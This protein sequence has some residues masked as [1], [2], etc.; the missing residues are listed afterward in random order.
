MKL[1][2]L[3]ALLTMAAGLTISTE[4]M[5][6]VVVEWQN[7]DNA[8]NIQE[9]IDSGD[10][11]IIIPD[12]DKTWVV[13][14]PI[15]AD[16]PNQKIIFEPGV[17]VKAKKG[18]FKGNTDSLFSVQADKVTLSGYGATFKMQKDD[19]DNPNLYEPSQF[20]HNIKIRGARDFVVEGLILKDSGGDGIL[21][22]HGPS[23]KNSIPERKFSSGIVRD[24]I[25]NNNYRQGISVVSA[26]NL[27]VENSIFKNTSGVKPS[28]GVDIEPDHDWQKLVNIQFKN[29]EFINN[30]RHGIQIALGKY[31]G[32]NVSNV[33]IEFDGCKSINNQEYGIKIMGNNAGVD[34]GEGVKGK[35]AFKDCLVKNS[36]EHGIWMRNDQ[37]DPSQTYKVTFENTK[38]VDAAQKAGE[39]YPVVLWNTVQPGGI[40]NIDFG[41]DFVI[42]DDKKRP[43]L[44]ANS[45]AKKHGMS[46]ISG[47][48]DVNNPQQQP[49]DLGENLTNVTLQ[50]K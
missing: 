32:S 29:N 19:Y 45:L 7:G 11:E 23:E 6:T 20:R 5:A 42:V 2:C 44:Y 18:A 46:N 15:V 47:V 17:V 24:V 10:S 33:S 26:K 34:V 49:T 35:I 27:L 28:A 48:I 14:Q 25:A 8:A 16:R 3:T 31:H 30:N 41:N 1:R 13:G 21:I 22:T 38:V 12:V 36:G 4:A 43:G 39:F 9:A 50:V 40:H 37:L